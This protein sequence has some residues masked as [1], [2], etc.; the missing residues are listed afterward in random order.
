MFK[1]LSLSASVLVAVFFLSSCGDGHNDHGHSH[2]ANKEAAH[3]HE[4]HESSHEH[5]A[6]SGVQLN[7]GARWSA[8][9][10]TTS[11]IAN[12]NALIADFADWE[13]TEA[14]SELNASLEEEFTGIFKNC[15]MTGEAHNQLHNYLIPMKDLLKR[16][17]S[18]EVEEREEAGKKLVHH[19]GTYQQFFE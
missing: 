2:D 10:E 1:P 15:T 17:Q 13:N 14:C 19:L 16:M 11:G 18:E 7:D 5:S 9:A 4:H 6:E 3:G 12:M 8:N